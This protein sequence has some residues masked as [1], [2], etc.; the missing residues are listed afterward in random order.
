MDSCFSAP[1]CCSRHTVSIDVVGRCQVSLRNSRTWLKPA[2]YDDSILQHVTG[3]KCLSLFTSKTVTYHVLFPKHYKSEPPQQLCCTLVAQV[4]ENKSAKENVRSQRRKCKLGLKDIGDLFKFPQIPW[5]LKLSWRH[6][7]IVAR[8]RAGG[9]GFTF[10]AVLV[11][12]S[13]WV[14]SPLS[15]QLCN[16]TAV[17][18]IPRLLFA[19]L[20]SEFISRCMRIS[21]NYISHYC[22]YLVTAVTVL[23]SMP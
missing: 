11:A 12:L 14:Y 6:A 5:Q 2:T 4:F 15:A 18:T 17:H 9:S 16:P 10:P 3:R 8:Y 23:Q 1:C 19:A 22:G 7:T 21:Q 20:R 13:T